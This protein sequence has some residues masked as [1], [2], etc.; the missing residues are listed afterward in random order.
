MIHRGEKRLIKEIMTDL[1]KYRCTWCIKD[2]KTDPCEFCGNSDA[3]FIKGC[4]HKCHWGRQTIKTM[5]CKICDR[6]ISNEDY[7]AGKN[8]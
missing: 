7:F 4:K 1:S 3:I 8:L 6:I 5:S 2:T